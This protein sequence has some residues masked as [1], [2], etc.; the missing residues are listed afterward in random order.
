MFDINLIQSVLNYNY[1]P[2]YLER[3]CLLYCQLSLLCVFTR[4]IN[5]YPSYSINIWENYCI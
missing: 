3:C 4:I 1:L 5:G 2:E